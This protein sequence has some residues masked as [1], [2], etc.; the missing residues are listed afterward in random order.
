MKKSFLSSVLFFCVIASVRSQTINDL[1][2]Q[3]TSLSRDFH[4]VAAKYQAL[5]LNT[6]KLANIRSKSMPNMDLHL[7]FENQLLKLKLHKTKITSD[8]FSVIEALPGGATRTVD[9][10]GA[11]FYQGTIE[12]KQ[13][14]FATIT[15]FNDRIMG[16][17]ADDKSN[18]ILGS[19]ENKGASTDEYALYRETDLKIPDPFT[20]ATPDQP[21]NENT[22][23][24]N[25]VPIAHRTEAVGEPI[26]I[27]FECDYKFYQDKGSNTTNVINYVLGFFNNTALL[28]ANENVKIQVSQILVW[29]TQD[30]EA[31]AAANT[32]SAV[33]T[34]FSNRMKTATYIGDYAH[35]LSTRSLGGGIAYIPG[36]PCSSGKQYRTAVSA[37]NNSYND[38]PTY[39]WTVE[40]VT[41]ELGHNLG[42][43]H[44]QWCGWV[45]GPLDNCYATEGG[46]PKGPAPTNGGTIMSYCHLTSSGINLNNGFGQQPGD[47]IRSVIGGATCFGNCRMTIDITKVDPSC[48][49]NNGTSTVNV[50]NGTGAITYTWSN[51]ATTSTIN[52]LAPG[53][54]NVTVNDAAGC[55]VMGVVKLV[56]S[57]GTLNASLSPSSP[58]SI[59]TGGTILLTA[60]N[61]VAYSY[62]WYKNAVIING[63]TQN[64]YTANSAGNYSVYVS[65]GSCS[66]SLPITINEIAAPSASIV[67]GGPTSFCSGSNVVLNGSAGTGY[68]YQWFNSSN[69]ITGATNSSYTATTSGSYTVRVSA[70][71]CQSTSPP[72]VVTVTTTP[73]ASITAGGATTFCS[74]GTVALNANTGTGFT[75]QWFNNGN[76]ISGATNSSYTASGSGSFTVRVSLNTCSATSSAVVVSVVSTPNANIT[77]GG[78]TTFCSGGQ[79][80][81]T[82]ATGTGLTYQWYNGATPVNGATNS[83]YNASSTG[84][85]TV[86]VSAGSCQATSSTVIVTVNTTPSSNITAGGPTTFC[87][88]GNVLLSANTGTGLSYQW[89]N[90]GIPIGGA[91]SA[92]YT[93]N[94]TGNYTVR[95]TLST[96]SATSSA[97]AVSVATMP[98][99]T[100]TAGGATTFCSGGHVLLS[101]P[102]GTGLSYQ[103][104][105]NGVAV[106]GATNSSYDAITSGSYTVRVS[107][108]SCQ[109]TSSAL[110]VTV[111]STPT[112]TITAGGATT[113]C[114]G[115]NV[116]LNANTGSGLTYQWFNNGNAIG[117]ATGS[118]YNATNNGSYT[119]RVSSG[120]CQAT[121]S[122]VAV[123][124][125][126]SPN[127]TITPG[128]ATTFC[129]GGHVILNAPAGTGLAYQWFNNG[130]A[131]NGA[132]NISYDAT[133]AGSYTVRISAGSCQ[134]TSSPVTVT[135]NST[136]T[137]GISAGGLTTF[138][139]GSSVVLNANTGSGLTYQWL[140]DAN[141]INGATNNSYTANAGGVYSVRV[142]SG[143]CSATSSGTTIVVNATPQAVITPSGPTA[144]CTSG[145]VDLAATTG[146]G[147]TYQWYN[148]GTVIGGAT[149]ST[150]HATAAGSYTVRTT[151]NSCQATSLPVVVT[152]SAAPNAAIAAAGPTQFCEG[153]NVT[154]NANSGVGYIYQWYRNGASISGATI[155]S[156]QVTI[157]G[158]YSV[159]IDLGSCSSTSSN[160]VVTV[161]S[162]P[163]V[164]VTP[165]M[166]TIQ[167]FQT[168]TLSAEGA[169]SYNWSALPAFVSATAGSAVFKPLQTTNYV[170][171]GTAVNGCKNTATATIIVVGCGDATNFKTTIKSPSRVLISWTNP[172]EATTDTLQFRKAGT[173][174]WTKLF[175]SGTQYELV[176]LEP[177]TNYEYNVVPLCSGTTIHVPSANNSFTTQA[178][179]TGV[180]INLYPNPVTSPA[181][182][183][184]IVDKPYSMQVILYN[185]MGQQSKII[186]QTANYPAGQVIKTV[187]PA[188][189]RTGIYTL[190][191]IIN[192]KRYNVTMVV[193]R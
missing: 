2:Q 68:T 116:V 11:V 139:S 175:V 144:F 193:I 177:G 117:G 191:I 46:C 160:S 186:S 44:T 148:S 43:N 22:T 155:A 137:A 71:S 48:G 98:T 150:Y 120:S 159:K 55:Q 82:T 74:G 178:L 78:P 80:T 190:A 149:G 135:V 92:N 156:Y 20:C 91:T 102:S 56:N 154:L 107:A 8:N 33:L 173:L 36:N 58:A 97:I 189:L 176:G 76:S 172:Q 62:Q 16:V 152:V 101:A 113:F 18:I 126:S 174:I 5:R 23:A 111:N 114:V 85:Y 41:H 131:I 14:S 169:A 69:A 47:K 181:K 141:S 88:G 128:G 13:K 38:Y 161:M 12:G 183:E 19:V 65:S 105:N 96:C 163:E 17:I 53:T 7:P 167:K 134:A 170:I 67:A 70:G 100:I 40:V 104:Y 192:G 157:A 3:K 118:T 119:V 73:S 187:D 31:A 151:S 75:Y 182:L 15:V 106:S 6:Q 166:S 94:S 93:A 86:R 143:N 54:Y 26:D 142:S 21:V 125:I 109:A 164:I 79:V 121:S 147:F 25:Q 158:N 180:Y 35:F 90:N 185:N 50:S 42:S 124:V 162:R 28:Y 184:V 87:S 112:A 77:A 63:A 171:E 146:S 27:Y 45:G 127:A 110:A 83:S 99:A 103:W 59:C 95:V 29:T 153:A 179:P 34:S 24:P 132:T 165:P 122:A 72:V 32:T 123:T 81:L 168:Q 4:A 51:G 108:G 49:Q 66:V 89:Y 61:N 30:P 10:S 37:I 133:A 145:S 130:N 52:S 140:K 188:G 129:S 84:N 136:P 60:T 1:F 64:T 57:G 138:C 9:Y 39:S 115:G